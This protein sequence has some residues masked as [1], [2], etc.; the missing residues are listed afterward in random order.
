MLNIVGLLIIIALSVITTLYG[1]SMDDDTLILTNTLSLHVINIIYSVLVV[2]FI[3]ASSCRGVVKGLKVALAVITFIVVGYY[4]SSFILA[5]ITYEP[6]VE[7][8]LSL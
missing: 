4:A 2:G 8:M 6:Q 7:L 3:C 1:A 5:N